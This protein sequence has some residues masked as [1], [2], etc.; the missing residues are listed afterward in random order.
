MTIC[1]SSH[2]DCLF[3]LNSRLFIFCYSVLRTEMS[4]DIQY[5]IWSSISI[6]ILLNQAILSINQE[7]DIQTRPRHSAMLMHSFIYVESLKWLDWPAYSPDSSP[8]KNAWCI[9]KRRINSDSS[10]CGV[11]VLYSARTESVTPAFHQQDN[12]PG[13][14]QTSN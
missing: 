6:T 11:Q 12:F 13:V 14:F 8:L 3:V 5:L 2:V 9:M 1:L 7:L 4:H 10:H